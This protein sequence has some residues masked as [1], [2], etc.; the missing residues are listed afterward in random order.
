MDHERQPGLARRRDICAE[1]ALLHVA[2]RAIIVIIEPGL[3][4][5]D[6]FRMRRERDDL[7]GRD[8]SLLG[9]M[10]R[11]GP[12]REEDIGVAG[13][14]GLKGGVAPHTGR[15]REKEADARLPRTSEHT[16]LIGREIREIEMAMAVDEHYD[17]ACSVEL[18][19]T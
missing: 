9:R 2:R 13:R 15:D 1:D 16:G 18:G 4:D 14:D 6:A 3:A 12:D 7:V 11:M 10:M 5:A 19:S 8:V 17:A